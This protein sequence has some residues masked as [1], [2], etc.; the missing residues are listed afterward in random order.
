MKPAFYIKEADKIREDKWPTEDW[1]WCGTFIKREGY[2]CAFT[3]GLTAFGMKEIEVI[4][5]K[6]SEGISEELAQKEIEALGEMLDSIVNVLLTLNRYL[7]DEDVLV[8]SKG[9]KV[10]FKLSEG[11]MHESPTLKF[12]TDELE[13][14][15]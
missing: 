8:L 7:K 13:M 5:L 9:T 15:E 4:D 11:V 12:H 10:T 6:G 2:Y 14:Y 1:V 3:Y